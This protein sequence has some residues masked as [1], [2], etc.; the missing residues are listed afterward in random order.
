M[1]M[2]KIAVTMIGLVVGIL[3][4]ILLTLGL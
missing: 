1:N 3:V 2:K 4:V